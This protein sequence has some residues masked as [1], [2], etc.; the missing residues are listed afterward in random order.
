MMTAMRNERAEAIVMFGTWTKERDETRRESNV[1]MSS[2]RGV[3]DSAIDRSLPVFI[4]FFESHQ[5]PQLPHSI[6][7]TI[8][9]IMQ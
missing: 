5:D 6:V 4:Y 9:Y 2:V 8:L 7:P 3:R 1:S